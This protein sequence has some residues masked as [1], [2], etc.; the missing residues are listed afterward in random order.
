[1]QSK[2]LSRVFS[3]TTV[4]KHRFFAAQL[5]FLPNNQP[6]LNQCPGSPS[7]NCKAGKLAQVPQVQDGAEPG[8]DPLQGEPRWARTHALSCSQG[9]RS[10]GFPP[11]RGRAQGAVVLRLHSEG[12]GASLLRARPE[13]PASPGGCWKHGSRSLPSRTHRVR[14]ST[15]QSLQE[16]GDTGSKS[17]QDLGRVTARG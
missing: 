1:M 8:R 2:G 6:D 10:Q 11:G 15:F 14:M 12:P 7:A 5:S 13:A 17:Q 16:A 3:N 9:P 4:Q